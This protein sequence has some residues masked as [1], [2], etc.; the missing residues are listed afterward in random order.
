MFRFNQ[1]QFSNIFPFYILLDTELKIVSCGKTLLK[2]APQLEGR[3]LNDVIQ[4]TRPE[5]PVNN[6]EQLKSALDQLLVLQ[7]N[8][9][10]IQLRGQL[11]WLEHSNQL[12]F[13]GSPWFSSMEQVIENDLLINDFAFHDP[14]IDLLH[15]LKTQEITTEDLKQVLTTVNRQKNELKKATKEIADIALF[16]TQ[17][18]DPLYRTNFQGEILRMNPAAE[19]LQEFIYEGRH[20]NHIE[21]FRQVITSTSEQNQPWTFETTSN[22]KEYSF[23]CVPMPEHGYLNI[24]GRDITEQKI[25]QQELEIQSTVASANKSGI[26]FFDE[27]MRFT[28]INNAFRNI[29]GYEFSELA[30]NHPEQFFI[31]P[32]TDPN[33]VQLVQEQIIS[34]QSFKEEFKHYRKDGSW[35][36]A[37]LQYMVSRDEQGVIR[38]RFVILDDITES[39]MQAEELERLSLAASASNNP[40][41]FYDENDRLIWSNKAVTHEFLYTAAELKGNTVDIFWGPLT[42]KQVSAEVKENIQNRKNFVIENI[43]YRKDRTSFFARVESQY[44]TT[45]NG[46][47]LRIVTIT[48]INA[49]KQYLN[50]IELLSLA[51]S[52]NENGVVFT[53]KDG[54][55]IWCN[56]GM[57]KITGQLRQGII[58]KTPVQLL[59]GPLTNKVEVKKML[60]AF[61]NNESFSHELI[62]YRADGSWYWGRTRG[63]YI[64]RADGT[65]NYFAI[66]EDITEEKR[67]QE[68]VKVL[69]LIA[70]DNINPVIIADAEGKITWVNK[71]FTQL[72]GFTLEEAAGKKPGHLLQGPETDRKTI[73]YLRHQIEKGEPFNTEI[74]NYHKNGGTYWLRVTGQALKNEFGEVTGYFALEEDISKEKESERIFRKALESIGDNVWEHDFRTNKTYFSK[75]DNQ[76]LGYTTNELTNNQELWWNSVYEEDRHLLVE[77][78]QNYQSGKAES[79]NLEYRIVHKD[80]SIKWV[81][82][83]GVVM[84]RDYSGKPL[85]ITGTHTDITGIKHIETELT[86]RVKQFQSLSE[87]IPGVI[88]EYE[89]KQDGTEGLRYISPAIEKL[90]GIKPEQFHNY[91]EYIHPDDREMIIEK[92][93]HSRETSEPFYAEARLVIPGQ[94]VRWHSVH[95]AFSYQTEDGDNVFTGFML[96][97]TIRK[98]AEQQ[99]EEQRRFYEGI[100]DNLPADIAVFNINHT[101]QYVNP[102]AIKDPEVREWIVGKS[103]ADYLK[104][105]NKPDSI[106]QKRKEVF[107]TVLSG[108]QQVSWEEA[109][110]QPDGTTRYVLRY[111]YPVINDKN[112]VSQVIGYGVDITERKKFEVALKANE[113][114]YRGIIAN[115]NLGMV[116]IDLDRKVSFANQSLAKMIGAPLEK[117]MGADTNDFLPKESQELVQQKVIERMKGKSEAFELKVSIKGQTKWWLVSSAPRFDERGV[118][119]GTIVI[120][121]DINDQKQLEA[122]LREAREHAEQLAHTKQNFLANMSHE[123]RTPMNAIL[124]MGNLLAK[125]SLTDQQNFY[126]GAINTSAENLLVIIN[127]ILDLSKIE[128]GKLTVETIGF[129]PKKVVA[130]TMKVLMHKAEEKGLKLTNSFCDKHLSEVLIGD[131]YRLNQVL[132]NLMSNA[133]KFTEKGTVDIT[134]EVLKDTPHSQVIRASVIDTGIGMDKAFVDTLFEKFTQE[135]NSVSRKYGGTGLGMSICKELISLMGGN[136]E[137]KSEKGK[138]T[139]VYFEIEFVKGTHEDLPELRKD[140]LSTDFLKG[141]RILVTDDNDMNRLVASTVLENYGALITEA[142]NGQQAVEHVKVANPDLILMDIQ[143]P[144]MN[145]F[146]ATKAIRNL[147]FTTPVIALTAN[148]IKGEINNCLAAGMNDYL[149]KP[150]KED[151]LLKVI[152]HWLATDID[153]NDNTKITKKEEKKTTASYDL[154]GLRTISQGN[155]GFIT[156]MVNL[157]IEQ[158]PATVSEIKIAYENKEMEKVQKLAHRLKPS[159]DNLGIAAIKNEIREIE[160]N[161]TAYG[162]SQQ[163]LQLIQ[164]VE[165]VISSVTSDL[166]TQKIQK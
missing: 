103:D 142:V 124:G 156:K 144:V 102:Q 53:D 107:A 120:C 15:V 114:K 71:S 163:L 33:I 147:G 10:T 135:Y 93:R 58:G 7:V 105:R 27:Q 109:L 130:H 17:N 131:P 50:Q 14:M 108:K 84:E 96:D 55:I 26:A 92:N 90:F 154:T 87:N 2:M 100:L 111:L 101:Y 113:E 64:Q 1:R 61:S 89:F 136:I 141:K 132:L 152:S 151:D 4:I 67:Q 3:L 46:R 37:R 155:E 81:L 127:D 117:L 140:V 16:P 116:E 138:G 98:N 28:W 145:G 133:I 159:I 118:F 48:N 146:E 165:T 32:E 123:I 160:K 38:N 40:V 31:G 5:L 49:E 44:V 78:D 41:L 82:D 149:S 12:L 134:C 30:G 13:I 161:A 126:L 75:S 148:A 63:Q 112:T 162:P 139:T 73:E 104:F 129:E 95:S 97:I 158:A 94:P 59:A 18:P 20:F 143:M 110:P 86:H 56:A 115:M 45:G 72:T 69:S 74:L 83:R 43:I 8:D 51:A 6:F 11:E 54:V 153:T 47:Q 99:L 36:W 66:I 77:S 88:Y 65:K 52:A 125:T 22:K 23:R 79:H 137:V 68:R 164:Q 25:I 166:K 9:T 57:M 157:F 60:N 122:D 29:T 150:F 62:Q 39:K 42:N 80:G 91:L 70:E 24:Y 119:A 76:F 34:K 121:L 21:L 19:L 128:A 106:L 35:F 85:R